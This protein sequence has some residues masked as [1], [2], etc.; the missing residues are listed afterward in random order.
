MLLF[1]TSSFAMLFFR[2]DVRLLSTYDIYASSLTDMHRINCGE[3]SLDE[4]ALKKYNYLTAGLHWKW[5]DCTSL[6]KVRNAGS[7]S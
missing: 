4:E 3:S 7:F 1:E 2:V 6:S 5:F